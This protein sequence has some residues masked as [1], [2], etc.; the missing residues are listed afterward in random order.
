MTDNPLQAVPEI[1]S[2]QSS[3]RD[4]LGGI[5]LGQL[6]ELM[7][8]GREFELPNG[9]KATL[10][11]LGEGPQQRPIYEDS[12]PQDS[13]PSIGP[14]PRVI[15][16][17]PWQFTFDFRLINCDQ[18]HIECTLQITGGGGSVI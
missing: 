4:Y 1:L 18:D 9:A 16:R 14:E 17:E 5:L 7:P 13:A 8:W 2:Q 6:H 12:T 10:A 15:G 11:K 3:E